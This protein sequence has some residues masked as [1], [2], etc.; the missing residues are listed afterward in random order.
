MESGIRQMGGDLADAV[1]RW[2]EEIRR[3]QR[4]GKRILSAG[5]KIERVPPTWP[6][7][8]LVEQPP[9]LLL[10]GSPVLLS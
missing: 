7:S 3:G 1:L 4:E 9:F 5:Q 6:G 8:S 2:R 10:A